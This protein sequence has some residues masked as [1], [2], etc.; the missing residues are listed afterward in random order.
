MSAVKAP[1]HVV[2][3]GAGM[4]GLATAWHL[5]ERGVKVTVLEREGVAAG[6]S[7]GNAGWLT[8]A[9][10]LPLSEP[11]V[12]TYGLKA[13]LNPSSPLY[14]PFSTNPQLLRFL[15]GFARHCTPGKWR[16]A[17]EVFTEV[18]RISLDAFDELADGGITDADLGSRRATA[19]EEAF[20]GVG[21]AGRGGSGGGGSGGGVSGAGSVQ[22][23]TK[24][25]DPFLAG[26]A[27]VKDRDA[28]V[29]E[30]DG[31]ARAGGRVDYDLVDGDTMR[32]IEPTLADGVQAGVRIRGQRFIN[33]PRFVESLA[34]AVRA[35]GGEILTGV[36]VTDVRDQGVAGV[37]VIGANGRTYTADEVVLASGAWLGKLARNFGVRRVV[38]AGRGYSFSV[39]PE[40]MPTHP[41]YFPA[42][43]VACTPL[44]ERFRVA[45]MMEF[46]SADAPLDPR[47][48]KAV[49]DAASP[50]YQGINWDDRQ[51][52]WVGSRPCTTDGLPLIGA[53]RSPRVHVAGGHGMWGIALGPL[54]GKFLAAS[55]TGGSTPAVMQRFNPLR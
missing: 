27:S 52:E 30:F 34:E 5:Q 44:G 7:W 55:M 18:N 22:E 23:P 15:A 6:S 25:A 14:I 12:L 41:I 4:V 21:G 2:I 24:I 26:F 1:E 13:M 46:R 10:T 35:R 54:T 16:E 11:S 51:D 31:V 36:D 40:V 29:H 49:I 9:L 53:S 43:R 20:A 39:V 48:I 50:M 8:P 42:Q 37:Q 3:V 28:M 32:S 47:R 19:A 17:M 45:G 38:Q 33:P